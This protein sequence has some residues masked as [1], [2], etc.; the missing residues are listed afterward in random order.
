M[1]IRKIAKTKIENHINTNNDKFESESAYY[2]VALYSDTNDL[3]V[4]GIIRH[5]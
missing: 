4:V 2:A 1:A 5:D 3:R